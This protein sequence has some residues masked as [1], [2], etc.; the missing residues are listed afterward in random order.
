MARS[1][2]AI[3]DSWGPGVSRL[4][5]ALPA[6]RLDLAQEGGTLNACI[7]RIQLPARVGAHTPR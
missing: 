3:A 1:A 4:I 7:H 6:V 2:L 5:A